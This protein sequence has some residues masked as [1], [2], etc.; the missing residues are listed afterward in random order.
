VKLFPSPTHVCQ[1]APPSRVLLSARHPCAAQLYVRRH[2][3]YPPTRVTQY[4][5]NTIAKVRAEA[6]VCDVDWM[7]L[8]SPLY[9][10]RWAQGRALGRLVISMLLYR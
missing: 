9:I 10:R 4:Y 7:P 6:Q 5:E 2:Y 3:F 1:R 8:L